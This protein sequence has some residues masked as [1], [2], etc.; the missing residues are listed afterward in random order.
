MLARQGAN[1]VDIARFDRSASET[2]G[3]ALLSYAAEGGF[4]LLVMGAYGHPRLQE[5]VLGGATRSVL[6]TM[7]LPVLMSH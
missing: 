3:G 4:D 2:T 7:T 5:T 6:L 1:A